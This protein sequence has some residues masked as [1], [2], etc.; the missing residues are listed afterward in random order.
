MIWYDHYN[1][2]YIYYIIGSFWSMDNGLTNIFQLFRV[3]LKY[4]GLIVVVAVALFL[5]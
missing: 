3:L 1:A 2:I 4:C 5:H